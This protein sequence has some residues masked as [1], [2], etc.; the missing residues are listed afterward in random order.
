MPDDEESVSSYKMA[1][2]A[3]EESSTLAKLNPPKVE[4][5]AVKAIAPATPAPQRAVEPV[6]EHVVSETGFLKKLFTSI[7]SP[8]PVSTETK[9]PAAAEPALV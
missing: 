1:T 7:F 8:K 3:P 2:D 4:Q 5:P 9:S 6:A